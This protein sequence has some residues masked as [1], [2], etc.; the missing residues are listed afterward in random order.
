MILYLGVFQIGLAYWFLTRAIR[1]VPAF[2]AT[3][4]LQLEPAT[5]PFW[6]WL[7]HRERPT[8]WAMA[9]GVIILSATLVNTWRNRRMAAID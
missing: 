1:H 2:E 8:A 9:G 7:L 3:T 5:S 4:M 6:T